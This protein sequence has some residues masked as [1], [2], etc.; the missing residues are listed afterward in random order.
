[1][2]RSQMAEGFARRQGSA[3]VQP[4][5]AGVRH[6]GVVSE[7]AVQVMEEKG[8]DIREHRSKGLA[9]VPLGEMDYVINMSGYPNDAVFPPDLGATVVSWKVGDPLGGSMER[10]RRTRDIIESRVDEFLRELW[11]E[12]STQR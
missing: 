10:F 4:Y 7:E 6:T 5:S 9:D 1:M 8:I 12:T 2:I 3:F 11:S